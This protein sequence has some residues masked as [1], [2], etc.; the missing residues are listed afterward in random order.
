MSSFYVFR[1]V[2]RA[3]GIIAGI[4]ALIGFDFQLSIGIHLGI[5][6]LILDIVLIALKNRCR[7]C[8]KSLRIAPI[9]SEE[10]CPHCG[11]KIE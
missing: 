7:F 8:K 5:G 3:V 11:C 6:I 9:T 4:A 10:F 2:C 1:H